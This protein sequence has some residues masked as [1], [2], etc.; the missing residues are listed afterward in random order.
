M[1][2][3]N[4][5]LMS[6]DSV[7]FMEWIRVEKRSCSLQTE[8]KKVYVN[9]TWICSCSLKT[10]PSHSHPPTPDLLYR[11]CFKPYQTLENLTFIS[12]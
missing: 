12:V 8:L 2:D 1:K 6:I 9:V 5:I 11:F 10:K 4:I 3:Y 7:D